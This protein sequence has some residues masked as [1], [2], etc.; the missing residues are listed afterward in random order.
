MVSISRTLPGRRTEQSSSPEERDDGAL[1]DGGDDMT[2][3]QHGT[4]T[5]FAFRVP[6]LLTSLIGR[7]SSA[8]GSRAREHPYRIWARGAIRI[9]GFLH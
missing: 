4:G 7:L 3:E 1:S 8:N 6:H 5:P 2:P 9:Y